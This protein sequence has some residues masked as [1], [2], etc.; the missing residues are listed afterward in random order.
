M[1]DIVGKRRWYFLFSALI[2]IP[3]LVFIVLGV[4][5][6]QRIELLAIHVRLLGAVGKA[7]HALQRL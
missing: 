7:L 4:L 3:G 6:T 5:G 2:T 1:F